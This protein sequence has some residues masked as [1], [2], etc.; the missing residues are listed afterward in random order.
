MENVVNGLF[1]ITQALY[2]LEYRD[3]TDQ[4]AS[5]GRPLWHPDVRLFEVWDKAAKQC[6]GEFY[7]DLYPR[8]NKYS[9]AA[10]WGLSEHKRWA[11]GTYQRPLAALVCNFPKPTPDKPALLPHKD[12][13]TFFHEFGHVLHHLLSEADYG[14]FAGTAVARDFVEAPSQMFE[15]WV[16]DKAVL[17]TFAK[18][19][20]T[21]EPLPDELIDGMLKGKYLGS[22]L[23]AERQFYYG[24]TDQAF[25]TVKGGVVDTRKVADELFPQVEQY[26]PVANIYYFASFGHMVGYQAGYYGYQWSLVYAADM[27]QRFEEKG[28]LSPEA[29]MYYRKKILARGSMIDE[30]ELVKDYLG[31][32]PNME[33]YVKHLGLKP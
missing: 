22:G 31:R 15:N 6:L 10:C 19:Y 11:D 26:A 5:K 23:F 3:V 4:A 7:I 18:H 17:R 14:W 16:W 21:G 25:H 28:M 1:S 29:G 32:D 8:P 13:E 30:L 24:L 2:G 9:H 12:V 33:A 27:A 20:K